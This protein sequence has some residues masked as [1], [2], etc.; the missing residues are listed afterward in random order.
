MARI[1]VQARAGGYAGCKSLPTAEAPEAEA[2]ATAATDVATKAA[3]CADALDPACQERQR[4]SS[5][6]VVAHAV[7]DNARNAL[8]IC[9][10]AQIDGCLL[11]MCQGFGLI[12]SCRFS[13]CFPNGSTS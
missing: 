2:V 8:S 5:N 13:T 6:M 4:K 1:G 10:H 11:T 3:D 7:V 12:A 9:T